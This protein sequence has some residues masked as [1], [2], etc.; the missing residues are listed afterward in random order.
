MVDEA[1]ERE[2][3][4]LSGA[5]FDDCGLADTGSV[6]VDV[7]ALFCCFCCDVE[8]EDLHYIAHQVGELS[9]IATS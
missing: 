8:V 3:D 1:D 9:V 7:G 5:G 4:G 2:E 6:E